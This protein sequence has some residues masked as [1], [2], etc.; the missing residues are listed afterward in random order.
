MKRKKASGSLLGKL[1]VKVKQ[2][3]LF[4]N[5]FAPARKSIVLQFAVV[6]QQKRFTLK[7]NDCSEGSRSKQPKEDGTRKRSLRKWHL[8]IRFRAP[9]KDPNPGRS[10][11][12]VFLTKGRKVAAGVREKKSLRARKQESKSPAHKKDITKKK[13]P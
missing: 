7:V 6:R 10:Q 4:V 12:P 3:T 8:R 11:V 13:R 5:C 2:L 1:P 9:M